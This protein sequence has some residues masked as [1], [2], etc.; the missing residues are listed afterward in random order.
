L[1]AALA[2]RGFGQDALGPSSE[3]RAQ[4]E[5]AREVVRGFR[6]AVGHVRQRP[7]VGAGL[8]AVTGQRLAY[9]VTSVCVVLLYRNYYAPD[10][11]FRAG[12]GGLSQAVVA[13]AIGGGAAALVTPRAFR[14]WG[15]RYWPAVLFAGGAAVELGLLLPFRLPL[16]LTG[17]LFLAFVAQGVK[18]SVDTLIQQQVEDDYRGRV[19]ALYDALFNVMLVL[20][21]LL[22]ATALPDDGRSPVSVVVLAAGYLALALA[23]AVSGGRFSAHQSRS[24]ATA[25]S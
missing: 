15:P 9:G 24:A 25:S 4:R 6:D 19:F 1:L 8:A 13:I 21:A 17:V 12:L 2:A 10:G 16:T 7:Q 11:F 20:A 3:E 5:T 23:Y 18:I 14:R 22:T